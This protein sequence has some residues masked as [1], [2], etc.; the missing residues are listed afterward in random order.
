MFADVYAQ[1]QRLQDAPRRA[2]EIAAQ[3]L[4]SRCRA[5]RVEATATGLRVMTAT[6]RPFLSPSWAAVIDG[7]VADAAKGSG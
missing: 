7:A 1:L 6:R 5:G 4:T 2:R 3:R